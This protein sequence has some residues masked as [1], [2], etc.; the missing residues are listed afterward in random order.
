MNQMTE[1]MFELAGMDELAR[2]TSP[3]HA[4]HPL[5]KLLTALLYIGTILSFPNTRLTGLVSMVLFPVIGYAAARIPVRTCFYKLRYVLPL[6]A[7]VGI[8]NPILNR[9]PAFTLG[10]LTVSEG[11]ISFLALLLKGT[12][13]LMASFLLVATTGIEKLCYALRLL[14]VPKILVTTLLITYRYISLLLQEAGTMT[15]AYRL[16]APGQRGIHI[17]AWGSFLGQL[18]LRSMDR[19]GE[20]YHSMQMRGFTGSFYYAGTLK[21]SPRDYAFLP[22]CAALILLFRLVNIPVLLGSLFV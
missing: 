18:L 11:M 2:R 6:V 3:M 5:P 8:F 12:L 7:A 21:A 10:A 9:A 22:L 4:L 20:L 16:R 13:S 1:A 15:N 19:A 17:S 14:R